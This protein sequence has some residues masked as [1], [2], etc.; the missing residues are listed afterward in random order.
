MDVLSMIGDSLLEGFCM[1]YD[2][3]WALVLGFAL[4]G[5]VQAFVSK[6]EMQQA[7]GDHRPRTIV[8]SSFFGM[9]SSS[10]SYAASALARSLFSRGAD[11]TASRVFMFASTKLV[12]E[13]GI[14]LWLLIG[15]QF[16]VAEFVGGFIMITILAVVLPRVVDVAE[17]DAA[18]ERLRAGKA[19]SGG[20]EEH[21][22][23]SEHEQEGAPWRSRVRSRAGWSDASGY[24][25]SDLTMLPKELVSGF[26]VA[27]FA[28]MA[29]PT[30]VWRVLFLTGHGL[31]STV[32][33]VVVGPVL[34]AV[35]VVSPL[36]VELWLLA[37][38]AAEDASWHWYIHLFAGA[39]LALVLRTQW[40]WYHRRPVRLPLA[41]IVLAHFYSAA[42][43][44]VTPENI[45][46]QKWQNV[47]AGQATSHYLP[48]RGLMWLVVFA[49][50]LGDYLAALERR[51]VLQPGARQP[52]NSPGRFTVMSRHTK[53]SPGRCRPSRR[54]RTGFRAGGS[55]LT[56]STSP[57]SANGGRRVG[58]K[59]LSRH[60]PI[61]VAIQYRLMPAPRAS[62]RSVVCR[63]R[64]DAALSSRR[65]SRSCSLA[66]AARAS[67]SCS[68]S[69]TRT[70]LDQACWAAAGGR[71][72]CNA[73]RPFS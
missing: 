72:A 5:A 12:V 45:P 60:D 59:G 10:R 8:R 26:V 24:T 58:H 57:A 35:A 42:P 29:V 43:D 55:T 36:A 30:S 7:L 66:T 25:I 3:L 15:W 62:R 65:R 17:V 1:F 38:Y 71:R 41:W 32:E 19:G 14:V 27:G 39:S 11:F 18:R 9:V 2:T 67:V 49:V 28:S 50:A 48:W 21:A 52:V 23:I 68:R 51:T 69:G 44:L 61:P 63:T 34:A 4:S 33:N 53:G 20:H 54:G 64:A 31:P 22:A 73:F 6:G 16:A 13:L 46:H 40:S 37:R 56:E 47:F 70:W